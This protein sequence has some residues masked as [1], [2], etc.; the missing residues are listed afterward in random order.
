MS[1][2]GW[3]FAWNGGPVWCADAGPRIVGVVNATPDSFTDGGRFA[4]PAAAA[5]HALVLVAD[6][7]QALDVGAES[8]RPGHRPVPWA[9]EWHRLGPVLRAVRNAVQVPV[10]VDTRHAETAKRALDNGAQAV[11]DVSGL[12]DPA[13]AAVVADRQSAVVV[14]HWRARIGPWQPAAVAADLL[15]SASALIK[16]GLPE[17]R[18]AIDPG[19]G[20]GKGA[21][22]NWRILGA[23]GRLTG[24]GHAVMVGASRKGFVA[25]LAGADLAA[26]DE[27]TAQIGLWASMQGAAMLRVHAPA[28]Q[29]RALAVARALR[30]AATVAPP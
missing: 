24:A 30:A 18:I 25:A 20:F 19:L 8:T 5:D 29:V 26:R 21:D 14:G 22:D 2:S 27:V 10:S 16:A 12:A 7:A 9:E 13:M 6:G 4:D 23:L 28:P 17:E 3:R 1:Q 11:N 15:A